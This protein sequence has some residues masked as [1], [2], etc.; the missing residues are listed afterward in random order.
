MTTG[1]IHL[2]TNIM[3]S[4]TVH[5]GGDLMYYYNIYWID[6]ILTFFIAIYLI[7]IGYD[8]LFKT[9]RFLILFTP[10]NIDIKSLVRLVPKI[11]YVS[12][13][14]HVYVWYLN[15]EEL[16]LEGYLELKQNI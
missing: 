16:Y 10:K 12:Q 11:K 7:W 6:S 8:L 5:L 1:Y 9:T 14:H 15:E 3:A 13:L 2:F 4:I